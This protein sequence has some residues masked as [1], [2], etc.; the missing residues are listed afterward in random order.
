MFKKILDF[1]PII[2]CSDLFCFLAQK[3][4]G[5]MELTVGQNFSKQRHGRIC[6]WSQ[7]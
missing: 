2:R 4:I 7:K 3:R 6:V 5:T 1:S